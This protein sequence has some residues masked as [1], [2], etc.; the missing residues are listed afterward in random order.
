MRRVII[1]AQWLKDSKCVKSS[2]SMSFDM[3]IYTLT[4]GECTRWDETVRQEQNA[5]VDP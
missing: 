1:N 2:G 5:I 3:V 4:G